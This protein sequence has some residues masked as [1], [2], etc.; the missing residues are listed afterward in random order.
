MIWLA[1]FFT[2]LSAVYSLFLMKIFTNILNRLEAQNAEL[3]NIAVMAV[4]PQ[5]INQQL[6]DR[7]AELER[8]LNG[9]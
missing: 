6:T 4:R 5:D 7:L 3:W 8:I 1:V 9:R 2:V